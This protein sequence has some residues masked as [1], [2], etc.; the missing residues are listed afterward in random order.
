MPPASFFGIKI[1]K[2]VRFYPSF[3]KKAYLC[4]RFSKQN[5]KKQ[6]PFAGERRPK[7]SQR[8]ATETTMKKFTILFF[9]LLFATRVSLAEGFQVNVQSARQ[10]GMGHTGAGQK[11]GAESMHFNPAGLAFLKSD[12]ETSAGM[13]AI[14]SSA[15]FRSGSLRAGTDNSISTPVFLYAGY[16]VYD[17]FS[18][19]LSL[20]T[21][22]GSGM[23]WGKHW[24]GAHLIQDITLKAFSIQPT[25]AYKITDRLSIG[26]GLQI[27]LG[28]VDLSRSMM[29]VSY[30]SQGVL[31]TVDRYM[32]SLGQTT[33]YTSSLGGV[34]PVSARLKGTS[35]VRVGYNIGLMY[36][37]CDKVTLGVSYRSR[38]NM[39][40]TSGTAG[41]TYANEQVKA[42][43][44]QLQA[45]GMI[46]IPALDQG[47]FNAELPL[48]S[49]TTFGISY[50]P[51]ERWELAFDLQ[52]VG[53]HAYKELNISFN[54]K[55]LAIDDIR[56]EKN[57]HNSFTYRL[58]AAFRAT[59][60]LTLRLGGYLDGS[61]VPSDRLNP[62]TPSM[63]RLS[64]TAGFTFSPSR[65]FDIDFG[66]NYIH[67]PEREGSYPY[68]LNGQN[69]PFAGSY[70]IDAH[71]L[72]LGFHLKF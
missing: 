21:P 1:H 63:N 39:K 67:G 36:D 15:D 64:A 40:V 45:L 34:A 68:E 37:L 6:A 60:R 3:V 2:I 19:G 61:P 31:P 25:A 32:A 59:D 46:A 43:L 53:W 48:P 13:G 27:A 14:L 54:E 38:I 56:S 17:N 26:A 29:P 24:A 65:H 55:Q 49:N 11:L 5:K 18:V 66:Y 9:V 8:G 50:R 71:I 57:Y 16:R 33:D 23:N 62:E 30:W 22:Y 7:A 35:K 10:S 58:G 42:L 52:L 72:S 4:R 70:E 41:L 44:G 20:T 47:T 12:I 69:L 28:N 51:A